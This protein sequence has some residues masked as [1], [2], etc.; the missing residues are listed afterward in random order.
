MIDSNTYKCAWAG[1]VPSDW[2][3]VPLESIFTFG[4]GLSITKSDLKETGCPVISYGQIHAKTCSG[5]EIDDELI[6]YV[7]ESFINTSSNSL[8][9]K[10]D[11]IVADTSEDIA[12]CGNAVRISTEDPIFSGYHTIT[13]KLK[14][15]MNTKYIA[16]LMRTEAW[17][18]QIVKQLTEVKLYTISQTTLK[19][20]Y[21]LL[22]SKKVQYAITDYLDS[23]TAQ[24]DEAIRRHN[25]IIE[26]IE[27]Y[28]RAVIRE[29]VTKG[30]DKNVELKSVASPWIKEIPEHW[31]FVPLTS[32]FRTVD[33]RNEDPDALL[34]SLYTAIGV[35]PRNEL[36]ERGNKATT[37]IDYKKVKKNDIIVNKL[38]AWMGAIAYSDYDGVTSPDYDV[39]RAIPGANVSKA[40]YNSY[41]R[42]TQFNEDC[43]LNGHGL[44]KMRW[45]TY[46]HELL[47]IKVPN[48]PKEEQERIS[49]Y[50]V[51]FISK[52]DEAVSRQQLAIEKLEEYRKSVIYDAVTGKIDCRKEK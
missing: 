30:I 16:Y 2:E 10:N 47:R 37:V 7:D 13:M 41:F 25:Q 42:Y 31:G 48:P 14:K 21:V 49:A 27:E 8:V 36:E 32:L 22:P 4:K 35:K 39:Y 46:P 9:S 51:E 38:L 1:E 45:R 20:T 29:V 19:N 23:V 15:D 26:R 12:G 18:E 5:V 40:Y 33:E 24:I 28:K 43:Y 34:L 17:R 3:K 52:T 6:R 11:I 44:M 50:L